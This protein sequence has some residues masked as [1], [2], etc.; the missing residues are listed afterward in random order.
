MIKINHPK[1]A[2]YKALRGAEPDIR[3]AYLRVR[4]TKET[5][6]AF[7]D[8]FPIMDVGV[9]EENLYSLSRFL[10]RTYVRR[11]IKKIQTFIYPSLYHV[12]RKAHDWHCG[13]RETNIVTI[14]KIMNLLDTMPAHSLYRVMEDYEQHVKMNTGRVPKPASPVTTL[15]PHAPLFPNPNPTAM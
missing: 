7:Q 2:F 15:N 14:E 9:V 5:A 12:L 3:C 4:K 11:Y 13:E 10:H 6:E 1:N 8:L